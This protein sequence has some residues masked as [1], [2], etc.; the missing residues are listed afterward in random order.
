[1]GD[2]EYDGDIGLIE[3]L[4]SQKQSL[5][6]KSITR[7][8]S[9]VILSTILL[10][11]AITQN[12]YW[13]EIGIYAKDA[14]NVEVLY[15]YGSA[16][17]TSFISKDM[18]NEKMINVGVLVSNAQNVTATI[19]GSLVYLSRADL[20]DHNNSELSHNDI[21][22]LVKQ[23]QVEIENI[24]VSEDIQ[25][26]NIDGTAHEDIRTK[27][28]TFEGL[29]NGYKLYKSLSEIGLNI[30][31]CT[32]EEIAENMV[33]NSILI[34][35]KSTSESN[36]NF[37]VASYGGTLF[38]T[39]V[40]L[41]RVTFSFTT[42][43][44]STGYMEYKAKYAGAQSQ[45]FSG[46]KETSFKGHTHSASELT[47]LP[48]VGNASG[49]I[50]INNGNVNVN[51]VAQHAQSATNADTVDGSHAWQM[52]TLA[53]DGLVHGASAWLAQI[54]YNRDSDN[55]FKL[56][57]G[58][59]VTIG[60][61]V[62]DANTLKSRDICAEVDSLKSS[63]V[64][65]KQEVVNAIDGKLGYTSGLTTNHAHS[66]YAWWITNMITTAPSVSSMSNGMKYVTGY[67]PFVKNVVNANVMTSSQALTVEGAFMYY[68]E[69]NNS[70]AL[71][72]SPVSAPIKVYRYDIGTTTV[73]VGSKVSTSCYECFIINPSRTQIT[74]TRQNL[75]TSTTNNPL[76]W[77]S[78]S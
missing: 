36:A 61:K 26:H 66:D 18:L 14:E 3:S 37:P 32:M 52:Q 57:V 8:G 28:A 21:R 7:K 19:D 4:V 9:Q 71:Y 49:N 30:A 1:M 65:G 20:E 42:Y 16:T 53:S 40:S 56:F 39:R 74:F 5:D 62:D 6:I 59:G 22:E 50:P 44:T 51:L 64:S 35:S 68:V 78:I 43:I 24:D 15:L 27:L 29:Q 60:T 31:T 12:F 73:N 11:S 10:Q 47:D 67:L 70:E 58:D 72:I 69:D 45:K 33:N 48:S 23:L 75:S 41:Q 54:Q 46:W 63:V 55:K 25:A 76:V 34:V 38:V 13:K 77:I 17:D 2:G